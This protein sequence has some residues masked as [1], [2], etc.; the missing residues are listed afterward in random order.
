MIE[1]PT[2]LP[3]LLAVA[4]LPAS[5]PA[6]SQGVESLRGA[7]RSTTLPTLGVYVASAIASVGLV[8]WLVYRR[9]A[10]AAAGRR[11]DA[12]QRTD[13]SGPTASADTAGGTATAVGTTD[14]VAFTM[15]AFLPVSKGIRQVSH[16]EVHAIELGLVVGAIAIWLHS[17]GRTTIGT[18]IIV[19]FVAGSL[20][21]RRYASK[22]FATLRHE[23]WYGLLALVAGA[24]VS[25]VV[26]LR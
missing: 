19:A 25:W 5:L 9:A 14:D 11:T 12:E 4:E 17:I 13:A 24:G 22:A 16:D 10:T 8:R 18:A 23:P 26:F 6:D 2:S 1:I 21:F 20:G 3:E 7:I 15:P